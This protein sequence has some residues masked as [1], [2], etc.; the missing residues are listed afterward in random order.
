VVSGALVSG[1]LVSGALVSGALVSGG[2]VP[3]ACCAPATAPMLA[4]AAQSSTASRPATQRARWRG[5]PDRRREDGDKDTMAPSFVEE[6]SRVD[7]DG[8]FTVN[9]PCISCWWYLQ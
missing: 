6:S 4:S 7:R 5:R 8:Y 3:G 2:S 9:Q 1:T